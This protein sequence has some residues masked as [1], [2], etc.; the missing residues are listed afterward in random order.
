VGL[1]V[2]G[3]PP[4]ALNR[5]SADP[6]GRPWSERK[7]YVWWDAEENKWT[8]HDVPDF[9]VTK[10]PDYEAPEDA[11][12]EDAIGGREPFIM[13]AD[14][15]GWLYVPAGLADG[16]L[17]THYE[18]AESPLANLLY[19]QQANPARRVFPHPLNRLAPSDDR[20]GARVFPYVFTT[21][22]LTEHHTA[23]GMS[24]WLPYLSELQP[25]FF[26]EVSPRLAAERGL[27]HLGWA[28][29]ISP[30]AAIEARVVVTER[31]RPV[32]AGGRTIHQI[33]LPYHWG[34]NGISTGDSANEL[35]PIVLD[36]N[37]H[38]QPTKADVCDIRPGRRPRGPARL[39]LVE[40]YQRRAG[41][42]ESTG[43]D[44]VSTE[45]GGS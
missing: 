12:C 38:I 17:P 42:T 41:I 26:C 19:G 33:G 28:T 30:R 7:A 2:A 11:E 40:E 13:Q 44:A 10:P 9:E 14:G 36:P 25:E 3:E 1:G 15:R 24:R 5:A 4:P 18:P 16:P 43:T 37:V 8:G 32:V 20:P 21:Y 6:D 45:R 39:A 23:G 35:L 34:H 27:E 31:V 22:R 29:I